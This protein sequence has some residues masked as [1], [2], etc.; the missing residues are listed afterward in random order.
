[1]TL[2]EY[3]AL[4]GQPEETFLTEL[5]EQAVRDVKSDLALR[6]V[7]KAEELEPDE[8]DLD[9]EV[10]HLAGHAALSPAEMRESLERNGRM[11]LLRSEIRKSK[12][13]RWLLE[14]VAIVDEQGEAVDRELIREELDSS[15]GHHHDEHEEDELDEDHLDEHASLSEES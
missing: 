3:L 8:S 1:M 2:A 15:E 5:G 13:M 7:A 9:E 6:A 14:H 12:A 11:P 10:V 4:T